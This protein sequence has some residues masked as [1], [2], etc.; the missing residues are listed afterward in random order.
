MVRLVTPQVRRELNL[1][2]EA[3][4]NP[5]AVGVDRLLRA[6][7]GGEIRG[8]LRTGPSDDLLGA[9]AAAA[10]HGPT[11]VVHP[12]PEAVRMLGKRLRGLGLGVAVLP[13]DWARAAGG[14]VDVVIGGRTAVWAT[15][16]DLC[17]ILVLDEHDETLYEQ[18]TPTWNARDVAIERARRASIGCVLL[19]PCPTVT[20]LHWAGRRWMR[21][22]V[23]TERDGWPTVTVVDRAGDEPWKRSL[24][25]T[26]LI[27]A[28]RDRSK[29]VVCV[30][31]TA[32][33]SRLLA[34]RMCRSLLRCE[35]CEAAVVQLDDSA[36]VCRR[37]E[38]TRPAV[39]QSC[40]SGAL[41]N[42][43]PGV[44]RLQVELEAA[45]ARPVV[46]V[47]GTTDD[48]LD[49]RGANVF[50]GTEAVLHRVSNADVVVFLDFDAELLAPRYRAGEQAFALL[51]RAA[52]LLGRR[53]QGGSLIIQTTIADHEV[54]QAA[55]LA[56]PGLVARCEA[57]RRRELG[58][59]PFGALARVSGVG[60]A[61]FVAAAP[62]V[63]VDG[64][65]FLIR[66][67][68]WDALADELAGLVRP[69]GS[70]LRVEVDPQRR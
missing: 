18:R 6:T 21:P 53:D 62:M 46:A 45:A 70:R 22:A 68:T 24:V 8:V 59:P 20:A 43:R 5:V 19:S 34:C 54:V 11:L 39:C 48:A 50:V 42:V 15:V 64:D 32:G 36:L 67:A 14:G 44:A 13:E 38:M 41:A 17:S 25:T 27:E 65:G 63:A 16:P 31:N 7:D 12:S 9:I 3:T 35:R 52:R 66:A 4:D 1:P 69:P 61:D 2:V 60:A 51:V 30:H 29:R 56:D 49:M 33:R 10:A 23:E 28:L 26:E 40:G 57:N 58:L 47:T 55:V 37:C